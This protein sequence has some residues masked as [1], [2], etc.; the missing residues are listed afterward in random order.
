MRKEKYL[1]GEGHPLK[2][3]WYIGVF[4]GSSTSAAANAVRNLHF[5]RRE[6]GGFLAYYEKVPTRLNP[7]FAK[8]FYP[9]DVKTYL[10][11]LRDRM[12]RV[13]GVVEKMVGEGVLSEDLKES[14]RQTLGASPYISGRGSWKRRPS[15]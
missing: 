6:G 1:D 5:I 7:D 14:L 4:P 9:L 3:G 2:E 15:R 13:L 11:M 8:N 10:G 12:G